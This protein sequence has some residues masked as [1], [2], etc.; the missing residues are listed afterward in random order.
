MAVSDQV[1]E[2]PVPQGIFVSVYQMQF[3]SFR[4]SHSFG[5]FVAIHSM[6]K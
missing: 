2:E 5:S 3:V 4:S 1:A 6:V